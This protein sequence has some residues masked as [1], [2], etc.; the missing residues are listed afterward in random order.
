MYVLQYVV[1]VCFAPDGAG[2]MTQPSMQKIVFRPQPAGAEPGGVP[3]PGAGGGWPLGPGPVG[4]VVPGGD[5]PTQ[6]NFYT[7]LTGTATAPVGGGNGSLSGDIGLQI[8]AQL[9]RI[10]GF[11]SGGG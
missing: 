6:A 10:Q 1:E 5:A 2:P 9:G 8:A 7:A 3:I 11:A 4:I